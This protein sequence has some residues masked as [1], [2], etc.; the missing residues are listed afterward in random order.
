MRPQS[1]FYMT[2]GGYQNAMLE[3]QSTIHS[4]RS[5]EEFLK[6]ESS[7]A[8]CLFPAR[9][10]IL[11]R[12][13]GLT[14]KKVP[15][16]D[17]EKW[18]QEISSDQIV[19]AFAS[20][21][22]S[23]PGSIMGHTFL[24]F[25]KHQIKDYLHRTIGYAADIPDNEPTFRYI[26]R[27]L[28]GGFRGDFSLQPYY[29]K[30]HE[31]NNMESRDI[32]EYSIKLSDEE[33][34][35]FLEHIWEL[36]ENGQFDYFYIDE[37]CA[38]MILAALDPALPDKNILDDL[39]AYVLPIETVKVLYRKGLIQNTVWRPSLR[40]NLFAKY[41]ALSEQ[42]RKSMR[43]ALQSQSVS[44][45]E[46]P[47]A[48]EAVLDEIE[49]TK[50]KLKGELPKDTLSF[51]NTALIKRAQKGIIDPINPSQPPSLLA[52]HGPF[53][54][55]GAW[56]RQGE[57]DFFSLRFRPFMHVIEDSDIGYLENSA[58]SLMEMDWRWSLKDSS[59]ELH[60][61]VFFNFEL[62]HPYSLLE[63]SSSWKLLG[64]YRDKTYAFEPA[65]GVDF[66]IFKKLNFMIMGYG[67]IEYNRDFEKKSRIW[68]GIFTQL[69]YNHHYKWK[70]VHSELI[71]REILEEQQLTLLRTQ[72]EV[73]YY[74][75][76]SHVD[77]G[78]EY[79]RHDYFGTVPTKDSI[80]VKAIYD[81]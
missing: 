27:G 69:I 64:V 33:K 74:N 34:E 12:D 38:F 71:A 60:E 41:E 39:D 19:I 65:L 43:E 78:I 75:V 30:V 46:N 8:Q 13:L 20:Q 7:P 25:Q 55:E 72:S 47:V 76:F 32:W 50:I 66:E 44:E 5:P 79:L 16:P 61:V 2:E 42:E 35:I 10:R 81:F 80:L 59:N 31:Y 73:R 26:Y 23:H 52:G 56:G 68:P 40:T 17:L 18:K 15:C 24:K 28:F 51:Q 3:L 62:T 53:H 36:K 14:F 67:I 37:N 11:Q 1:R 21:F 57:R 77:F 29:E 45:L 70:W 54:L 6:K 49:R 58:M 9:W 22:I 48:L 4:F 63:P